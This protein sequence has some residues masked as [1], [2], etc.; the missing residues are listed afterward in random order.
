[1]KTE[2]RMRHGLPALKARVMVRGLASIDKRTLAAQALLGWKKEL[3]QDLG[4][5]E[6]I[7]AQKMTIVELCVRTRLLVESVDSF[8]LSQENLVNKRRKSIYPI[9][10]Q[11]SALANNLVYMLGQLGLERQMKKLPGL[12]EYIEGK[13]KHEHEHHR[14]DDGPEAVPEDVSSGAAGAG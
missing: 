7:S 3:I 4:G 10:Q 13:K 8:I 14:D 12:R 11:R 6:S 1:M 2:R 5:E 9:V